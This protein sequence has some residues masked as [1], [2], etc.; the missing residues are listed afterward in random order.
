MHANTYLTESAAQRY[1]PVVYTTPM[2]LPVEPEVCVWA[3]SVNH[4]EDEKR[5]LGA[6]D[7]RRA[8]AR[9]LH[10]IA[11]RNHFNERKGKEKGDSRGRVVISLVGVGS[12]VGVGAAGE[13]R[14]DDRAA[15]SKSSVHDVFDF[16]VTAEVLATPQFCTRTPGTLN[17]SKMD[18]ELIESL[19]QDRCR[20]AISIDRGHVT[21]AFYADYLTSPLPS[22]QSTCHSPLT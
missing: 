13:R 17:T 12:I 9:D 20:P 5:V 19:D 15:S 3:V 18:R 7:L 10:V 4:V 8:V 16:Q 14:D 21:R 11:V 22:R 1:P 6:H 2:G